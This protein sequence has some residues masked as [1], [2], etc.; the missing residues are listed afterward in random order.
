[1]SGTLKVG[2][3]TLATHDTDT[4]VAKI[5]LGSTSDVILTDSAGNNVLSESGGLVTLTEDVQHIVP[6]VIAKRNPAGAQ[7]SVTSSTF[8]KVQIN[9]EE[10]DTHNFFDPTTNYRFT[11]TIAG[12]YHI[13]IQVG[14][15]TVGG[16]RFITDLY[17]TGSFYRRI[18]D[19]GATSNNEAS[20]SA[21]AIVELNGS[22]DNIE[23]YVY[24]VSSNPIVIESGNGQTQFNAF[25]IQR[26]S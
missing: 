8:T 10:A 9:T 1:M 18:T 7:Q 6:I 19:S 11:P 2:G 4:N 13:C 17:K 22:T 26:T 23:V 14:L 3:K 20:Y 24:V 12:Y 16:T 15:Q 21:S 5:Q 25:L